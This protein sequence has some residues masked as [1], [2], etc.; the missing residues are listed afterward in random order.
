MSSC[1][2]L[3]ENR[4]RAALNAEIRRSRR[5]LP[6]PEY[7][8]RTIDHDLI[9]AFN[10]SNASILSTASDRKEQLGEQTLQTISVQKKSIAELRPARRKIKWNSAI[11]DWERKSDQQQLQPQHR[12]SSLQLVDLQ[13]HGIRRNLQRQTVGSSSR[14]D[15][16]CGANGDVV[17]NPAVQTDELEDNIRRCFRAL[18]RARKETSQIKLQYESVVQ[19]N[20]RM[21]QQLQSMSAPSRRQS[22]QSQT[23]DQVASNVDRL[24]EK[25]AKLDEELGMIK[26]QKKSVDADCLILQELLETH[27]DEPTTPISS[28]SSYQLEDPVRYRGE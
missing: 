22:N 20:A 25:L 8:A 5:H 28:S 14:S 26:M 11:S 10:E 23:H 21:R 3:V 9:A 7:S 27:S 2:P 16:L 12:L 4:G 1:N 6:P 15:E 17:Q 24:R 13:I 19:D 18:N